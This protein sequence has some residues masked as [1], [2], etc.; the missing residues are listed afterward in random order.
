MKLKIDPYYVKNIISSKFKCKCG[1][2]HIIYKMHAP[3]EDLTICMKCG[4][5][6]EA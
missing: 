4:K 6:Y 3:K 2:N 1:G 5:R